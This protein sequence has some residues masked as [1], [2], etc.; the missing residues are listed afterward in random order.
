MRRVLT[1]LISIFTLISSPSM[2]GGP[3]RPESALDLISI[4][5]Q[6]LGYEILF[7]PPRPGFRAMTI[8]GQ[9]RIEIYAR[10][11]DDLAL[12]AYDI[13]HELGHAIDLRYN[14]SETRRQ[15]ME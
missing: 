11:Q 12:L 5:W 3:F 14:T 6:A 8:P 9:H 13:A 10:P 4:P 15:W 7:M 1:L 2:M